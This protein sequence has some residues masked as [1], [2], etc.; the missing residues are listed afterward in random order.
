MVSCDDHHCYEP[1]FGNQLWYHHFSWYTEHC[2]SYSPL[3]IVTFIKLTFEPSW[4]IFQC[5]GEH[6]SSP[7]QWT[8]NFFFFFF[9]FIKNH[10]FFRQQTW[11]SWENIP[12]FG[13]D[14]CQVTVGKDIVTTR[15]HRRAVVAPGF[16]L[17]ALALIRWKQ[18]WFCLG[19]FEGI[20]AH[21]RLYIYISNHIYIYQFIYLFTFMMYLFMYSFY[22]LEEFPMES[23]QTPREHPDRSKFTC[24]LFGSVFSLPMHF[25]CGHSSKLASKRPANYSSHD[26]RFS[27]SRFI[28]EGSPEPCAICCGSSTGLTSSGST[29]WMSYFS[30]SARCNWYAV[31]FLTVV[32][33]LDAHPHINWRSQRYFIDPK[34]FAHNYHPWISTEHLYKNWCFW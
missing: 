17:L 10:H 15:H 21:I 29:I 12:F 28:T 22:H 25:A 24:L 27:W 18:W 20:S 11:L 9:F 8:L 30:A 5:S 7:K 33:L 2:M 23:W 4:V 31:V 32:V 34:G 26:K 19:C 1:W 6:I 16:Q 3:T 14:F 13:S